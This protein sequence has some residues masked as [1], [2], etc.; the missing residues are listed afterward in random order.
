[1]V[2]SNSSSSISRMP[3]GCALPASF[4][5]KSIRPNFCFDLGRDLLR[6]LVERDV[7]LEE[8]HL[9]A[10]LADFAGRALHLGDQEIDDRDVVAGFRQRLGAGAA[11]PA[12]P[13]RHNRHL[14][15]PRFR[16]HSSLAD[17][18]TTSVPRRPGPR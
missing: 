17:P 16:S 13:A 8:H 2:R 1:M 4:S 6:A 18:A 14:T 5:R 10:D 12:R 9:A 3:F 15:Q 11:D 7:G